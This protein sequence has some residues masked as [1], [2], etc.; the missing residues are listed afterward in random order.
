MDLL[1]A[2]LDAP[3]FLNTNPTVQNYQAEGVLLETSASDDLVL[4]ELVSL[5]RTGSPQ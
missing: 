3:S 5:G 2:V 1:D 4:W